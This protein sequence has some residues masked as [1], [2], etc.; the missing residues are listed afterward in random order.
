VAQGEGCRAVGLHARTA[1]Q[2]YSG[3]ARW[4][5]IADLKG[6]LR[7]PVLGNGDVWEAQDALRMMRRTGC[8]GVIVGRGC[9]GR[10]WLFRELAAVFDGRDPPDPPDWGGVIDALL[11]HAT[12]VVEWFGERSGILLFRKFTS[13]YTKGF[14]GSAAL[15]PLLMQARTLQDLRAAFEGADRSEP[16]P[17]A[18]MRAKRGKSGGGQRVSLPDG[19]LEAREDDASPGREAE[20][21][22]SGG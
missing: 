18:A 1:A 21:L 20:A 3:E 5:A 4:E 13:W 6:L 22:V 11:E 19:W 10:P 14:R 8:D 9:L 12:L 17:V 15:R 16:F 7:V 2:L